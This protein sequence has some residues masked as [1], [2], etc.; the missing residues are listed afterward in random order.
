MAYSTD[1]DIFDRLSQEKVRQL[2]DDDSTGSVDTDRLA[3][4]REQATRKVDLYVRRRYELPI[5]DSDA[6][7]VLAD[8]ET[9]LLAYLLYARRPM[10][11]PEDVAEGREQALKDLEMIAEDGGLG[12]DQDGDGTP[13][14][15]SGLRVRRGDDRQTFTERMDGRY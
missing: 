2:T 8:I 5:S 9:D 10:E 12:I 3:R 6:L 13:D 14:G 7:D 11:T 1:E 4:L 15:G